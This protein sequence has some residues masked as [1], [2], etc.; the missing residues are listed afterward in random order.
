[1]QRAVV[2][3][4][5]CHEPDPIS[6]NDCEAYTEQKAIQAPLCHEPDPISLKDCEAYTALQVPAED[7]DYI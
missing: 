1:M 5:L 6:L 7:Y 3:A 4:P 2:Q